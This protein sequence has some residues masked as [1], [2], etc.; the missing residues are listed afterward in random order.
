MELRQLE[1][2]VMVVEEASFT[3]AAARLHVAQP[4]ISSQI[5]LLERELGQQLLDRS[6]RNVRLTAVGA[7]VLPFAR[8]ALD[9]VSSARMAV[10]QLVGLMRGRLSVGTVASTSA[11][12]VPR[13]LA[14]Y[15]RR[16]PS[17]EISLS[18]RTSDKLFGALHSGEL[19]VALVGLSGN[20]P[21]GIDNYV[22]ADEAISAIVAIGHPLAER[23]DVAFDELA[24][25]PLVALPVGT[26]IRAL[27]DAA[28]A[29]TSAELHV[30]FEASAPDAVAQLARRGL[31]VAVLP[32]SEIV[33]RPHADELSVVPITQPVTRARLA[34]AWRAE[35]PI[36]PAAASFVE[37]ARSSLRARETDPGRED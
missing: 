14:Q 15:H 5:R 11:I 28:I 13:L 3:K 23:R 16:Y 19:D 10:D 7:A 12:D 22:V 20:L 34:I 24:Q 1:Y 18:E 17:I 31:G 26:G 35:G 2:F 9:A 30:A 37:L 6:A 32:A 8:T 4:G 21:P 27:L 29:A 36:S 25:W 33:G